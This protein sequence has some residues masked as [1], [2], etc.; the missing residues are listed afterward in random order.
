MKNLFLTATT[1][2]AIIMVPAAFADGEIFFD[3]VPVQVMETAISTAP[4]LNFDRVSIETENG[5]R[6]YEFEATTHDG[7]HVEVDVL[8]DGTLDEVEMETE[9]SDVPASVIKVLQ[10]EKPGFEP[11]FIE[12]SVRANGVFAY[13]FSGTTIDGQDIDIEISEDGDVLSVSGLAAS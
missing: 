2:T 4:D 10:T 8:E 5:V 7:K 1:A 6:V 13:E 9:L 3:D 11:S 12:A